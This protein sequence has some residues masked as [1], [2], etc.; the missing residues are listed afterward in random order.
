[1]STAEPHLKAC[2]A[3]SPASVDLGLVLDVPCPVGILESIQGLL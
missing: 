3:C 2:K 1:M